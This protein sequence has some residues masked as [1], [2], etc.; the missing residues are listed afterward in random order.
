MQV[1][2]L[3]RAYLKPTST[4]TFSQFLYLNKTPIPIIQARANIRETSNSIIS[5]PQRLYY[6]PYGQSFQPTY[7]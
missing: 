5:S 1:L 7:V 6:H 3:C 4:L 2:K